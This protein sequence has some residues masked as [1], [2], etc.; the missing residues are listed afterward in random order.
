M[1]FRE[2]LQLNVESVK[3]QLEETVANVELDE[4][5]SLK[6]DNLENESLYRPPIHR[7]AS[8]REDVYVL[9]EIVPVHVL[10]SL[11]EEATQILE[12]TDSSE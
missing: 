9:S 1:F 5:F 10:D 7:D 2:R 6:K 11:E 4:T 12:D 8:A 3:D